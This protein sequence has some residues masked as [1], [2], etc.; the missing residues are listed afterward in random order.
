VE[1]VSH[2]LTDFKGSHY[3]KNSLRILP[4]YKIGQRFEIFAGPT[5]N[6]VTYEREDNFDFIKKHIWKNN[7]SEDFQ[8]VYFGFNTGIQIIL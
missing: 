3:F 4:A 2:S 6:Y 5:V 7:K 8:G 1:A